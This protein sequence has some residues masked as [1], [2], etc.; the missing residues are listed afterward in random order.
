MASKAQ[1]VNAQVTARGN[2]KEAYIFLYKGTSKR[3]WASQN[4]RCTPKEVR[5][6]C[7]ETRLEEMFR[8]NSNP[9][10]GEL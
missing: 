5:N 8:A 10:F 4:T 2:L 1:L 7:N 9:K 6:E 3:G